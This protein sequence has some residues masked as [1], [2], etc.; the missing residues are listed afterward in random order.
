MNSSSGR[1][2]NASRQA[3][4]RAALLV[5][6]VYF[7]VGKVFALPAN[8]LR[9]WRLSAWIVS[10]GAY[11][12]HI[13]YEHYRLG[14]SPRVSASHIAL[15]VAIGAIL[16]AVA[17]MLHSLSTASAIRPTAKEQH[18]KAKVGVGEL[19]IVVP[20]GVP[21]HVYARAKL[22]DVHVLRLEDSG[23]NAVIRTGADGGYVI[24]ARVGLGSIDV[25]RAG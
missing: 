5:G 15:A 14:S 4:L 6:V 11:A 8:D 1:H 2:T 7:V 12:A 25:V 3:W 13:A 19:R 18:V 16:L 17:G 9:W 23:R 22:G 10:G 24:D 21:V 20:D